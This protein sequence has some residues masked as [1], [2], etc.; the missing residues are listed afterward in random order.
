MGPLVL[1]HGVGSSSAAWDPLIPYLDGQDLVAIDLPGF[2]GAPP[3]PPGQP[4][5]VPAH[6]DFVE[7]RLDEDG[8][9][10]AHLIGN[11][12]GG[13]TALELARR[14]RASSVVALSPAGMWRGWERRYVFASLR[15]AHRLS[16]VA[17]PVA[18]KLMELK[19]LRMALWQYFAH[20]TKLSRAEAAAAIQ[21]MGSSSSFDDFTAWT[22]THSPAGLDEIDCP[23]LIAWGAKDR[24]LFRR[25][26]DRIVMEIPGADFRL[27]PG[28]GHVPMADDPGLVAEAIREFVGRVVPNVD[29]LRS[30]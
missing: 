11:S 20:P 25:Q 13:W 17:S 7:R 18:D 1:V 16:R 22:S 21:T 12:S 19:P 28:A 8:I 29:P 30:A 5:S 24:L 23:V 6:A 9:K 4:A 27:L 26:A 15:L 14:G 10:A 2:G 3:L